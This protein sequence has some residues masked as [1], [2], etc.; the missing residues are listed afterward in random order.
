MESNNYDAEV[1]ISKFNYDIAHKLNVQAQ[2]EIDRI[3][4]RV[5]I[6]TEKSIFN[7]AVQYF[8]YSQI[9]RG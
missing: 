8:Y 7:Y 1:K 4:Q 9:R 3:N 5:G 6:F 2:T